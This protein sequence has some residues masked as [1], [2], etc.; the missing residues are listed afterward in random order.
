MSDHHQGIDSG[1]SS[2]VSRRG[3]PP[4]MDVFGARYLRAD[5]TDLFSVWSVPELDTETVNIWPWG[6]L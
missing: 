1:E 2:A 6:P 3:R 4:M 5:Q